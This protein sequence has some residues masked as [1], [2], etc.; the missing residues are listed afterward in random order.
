MV[1]IIEAKEEHI[2]SLGKLIMDFI[3]YTE[4]INPVFGV[5]ENAETAIIDKFIRPAMKS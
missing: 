4:D 2:P 5:P 3:R 1:E